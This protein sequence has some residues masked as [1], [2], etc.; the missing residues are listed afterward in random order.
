M[1]VSRFSIFFKSRYTAVLRL[2]SPAFSRVN[3]FLSKNQSIGQFSILR[4]HALIGIAV[5]FV[6]L[7]VVRTSLMALPDLQN[8]WSFLDPQDY[9][10]SSG[11]EISGGSARLKAQNYT[12]DTD[13][14]AL[15]HFDEA[16]GTNISDSSTNSNNA[17]M[18]GGSFTTGNLNSAI[19]LDNESGSIRSPTSPTLNLG[20]QH[21][22]EAWTKFDTPFN[23]TTQDNRQQIVDKG[24]YQLYYDNETGKLTYELED[25]TASTWS[26][27]AG[28]DIN[29]GWDSNGKLAVNAMVKMGSTTYAAIGNTVGDAEVW[30]WNGAVWSMVGG[31]PQSI[32]NSWAAQTYEGVYSL[33]T[34]GTNIYAGLGAS[35][36]D[37]EVW[38][39]DGSTWTKIGGDNLNAGWTNYAEY[40]WS[41][42]YLNG[43]VYAGLGASAGDAE[44]WAWNGSSWSKIG[45][46]SINSGW[47]TTY[48]LSSGITND[49][50]SLYVGLGASA[51]DAEVWKWN[52]TTWAKIGGDSLN[53]GWDATIETVR[54]LRYFGNTLY[55]GLGDTA[56]DAD[57]WAWNG[58][59]WA[60]IGG[61]ALNSSWPASTYEQVTAFGY[62]GSN[63]YAGLGTTS[64]DGEVWR[65]DG[66]NWAKI[67]GDGAN[68]SWASALGDSVNALFWDGSELLSG[69][70]DAGGTGWVHSWDGTTWDVIGGDHVNKSWGFFGYSAV[71]VMQTYREHMY[72]GMGNTA[73]SATVW[74][75]DGSV[76]K[77]VGGQ[78]INN[79]WA[80]STY[81]YVASMASYK[82]KLYV[83]LGSTAS[84]SVNDGEVWSWDGMT[85]A[86][87]GGG[88]TNSSW[89]F[90][91]S[92]YGEVSSL[93]ADS[94]YL[95]AGLGAAGADG[96]V[97]RYDGSSWDK[98]GGDSLSGGWTNYAE[99]ATAMGFFGGDLFAGLGRGVGDGEV[100]KW[101]GMTWSKVG[102][103]GLAG[104]WA[105]SYAIESMVSYGS[106]ICVGLGNIT[107]SAAVWCW[108]GTTWAQ[109]GGD[110]INSSWTGGAYEK[111]KTLSAYNG[112]L[113]AGLGN[114]TGEGEVWRWNGTTW[115]KV[116]G[117]GVNGGWTGLVEEVESFSI[118]KGKL[119]A[120][121]GLTANA[122]AAVWSWGNN[123]FV[124]SSVS[125]F[126]TS[127]HHVAGTYDGTTL[128]LY[129]D[130]ATIGSLN[131]SV[132]VA[133]N[134]KDLMIG[135][136]YGGREQG[137]P[138]SRF[139]GSLDEVRL[140]GIA[141]NTFTTTPYSTQPQ[142]ISPI[143]SIRKSG[144]QH[145]DSLIQTQAPSGGTI[146]YRLSND[147]G[148]TWL[149]WD[150]L[151]W[152]PS[153]S[154][155]MTN[156][157]L[158]VTDNFDS[159][160][161]TF[162][163]MLW[164]AVMTS[165][166]TERT[167]L[168]DIN[169]EA[170]SDTDDPSANAQN[171]TAHKANGG[172]TFVDGAW[173]N[174]SSPHF[175]WDS[176]TDG[177]AGIYGYCAYLGTDPSADPATTKGMLG[178][179]PRQTGN[180][181]EFIV[182]SAEIDLATP[183]YL[184]AALATSNDTYYLLLRAIDG[185]GNV[186]NSSE[187]FS[188]K[189]DN[190][191]PTNPGFITAPS[192][193]I[194]TKA[195]EMSWPSVGAN[196]PQDGNSGLA[197]LQYKIGAS[198]Q[199]Y[200][201]SHSGS[202]DIT[203]LLANDGTYQTQETPDFAN[204]VDGINTVYFRTW[205]LAGNYTA[206]Y[207]TA[208]LKINTSG[209][210]SEPTNLVALPAAN[211]INSFGFNWDAP[212]TY[213]GNVSNIVYCYTV[214]VAPSGSNCNYTAAGS[215]ELTVGPYATQ[216]GVNTLY[217]VARDESSNINYANY[218]STSFTANTTA[219]GIPLN[220]DIVDVS[221]KN[222]SNWRL[223][224]T[225]DQ[226]LVGNVS[227]YRIY[228]STNGT[229]FSSVGTSSSTTYIDAGL[230]QQEYHYRVAA[231]DNTNNCGAF[232]STVKETPTGKF[233]VPASIVSGPSVSEVTTKHATINWS[234]DRP[235]DSKVAIGT[236]SGSYAASEVGSSNQVSAH[237]IGLDNLSPGTTYY[238]K[239]KWT[240]EDGNTGTSQEATFT[241]APAPVTK[242]VTVYDINL[243]SAAIS[244]TTRG[245]TKAKIYYGTSESF[246]GMK[247]I[248]TSEAESLYEVLLP[249]LSDG[250]KYFYMISTIDKEGTEYRGQISSFTTPQR[251]RITNLRFQPI[252]GEPTGTQSVT[253]TTNVPSTSSVS[254]ALVNGNPVDVSDA[255][256]V[257]EHV[258]V[259]R[260]LRDDS[261]Y[262]LVA[263]SRD[264]SGNLAT[265]DRQSFR[266]ALD[267]RPPQ[268][269]NV[270]VESSIRGSGSEARGQIVVSWQTDEPS[271]SQIAYTEG[272]DA[273]SFNSKTAQDT[274]LTT[275]HI[276]II[277]DLPTS[278]VYSVQP[279]SGDGAQNEG[280]GETQTA[281]IGR[282]SDNA[283]TIVFNALRAIF[284]V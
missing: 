212:V 13:T 72:A 275:E 230:S 215:T 259:I 197:G 246:G 261:Q 142:T 75:Y 117:S 211:T 174:G 60:K 92:H 273:R 74:Q 240:D 116:A 234:T 199:W 221:I 191:A 177:G 248:N 181:C 251:P 202:G 145:W 93:A 182:P 203:D 62:D 18:Q 164:Q 110:D 80:P 231:C 205:D 213:V 35:A 189:F 91:A 127:W 17:T 79:S 148:A 15:Y 180:H 156:T 88:G 278:R 201:D 1:L 258:I 238:Y 85:W 2:L 83:G 155:A 52:G 120:G 256:Q 207:T 237:T 163:G 171:I 94:A 134:D 276:V 84:A 115:A 158:V 27:V 96:E 270:S 20:Q 31:G 103:D 147:E 243:S 63:L 186:A 125:S 48:E 198:G 113:Y 130:G 263:Q 45:G 195:V 90:S 192:G 121:T 232:G 190:T 188:F 224:L 76:W 28:N 138:Q 193:F 118:Y 249:E 167:T 70:Y 262:T 98:I 71:Q 33:T 170:T 47:A 175:T 161:V 38:R 42:D 149:Y 67:G 46:D 269:S 267:T 159:F 106:K 204:L 165:N 11:V 10:Y 183:G 14:R 229:D 26:Q 95:Y 254:Y 122:D 226:P 268:V 281:I 36:G 102:G 162:G 144:V 218:A 124:Q 154:L 169:V 140:S 66:A 271:T 50:S 210:P 3:S 123:A 242:E 73:G 59:S 132:T 101:N 32:N 53:G 264:T 187:Q 196:S 16:A 21:T 30:A 111:V 12:S 179:S 160:P 247:E 228:R 54:S 217:V 143:A 136:G 216:P 208:T 279:V 150:G 135:V 77:I 260:N 19:S 220:S 24:N 64:G 265:S 166:G 225:W 23:N 119:Y 227:S 219:P 29:G 129:L 206:N 107:G 252:D 266:T 105:N 131:R 43:I 253:W 5:I 99:G 153:T 245:A 157:P 152:T 69:T 61:D 55:A 97:W 25:Q 82:G 41:L 133:T 209:A 172:A 34:D 176:A 239:V 284:G 51:A 277:S 109:I 89:P 282:A 6:S 8:D 233:T 100:W 9:T 280:T 173:T 200:G 39:Y 274:R 4:R 58:S 214:N 37:G 185:A 235:S 168:D 151:G 57:V 112:D 255:K 104:S 87:V 222:T 283:L 126:D 7:L 137:K 68:N 81:E 44:V 146:T 194:N 139:E 178:N 241:T 184:G 40:V 78:G 49:G 272:S 108:D 65:Y 141:R 257:T 128:K 22:I 244:F 250:T 114:T 56:G 223:A 86:K 236:Q